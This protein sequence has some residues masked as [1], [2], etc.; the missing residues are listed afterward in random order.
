VT[1]HRTVIAVSLLCRNPESAPAKHAAV[2][3]IAGIVEG[4]GAGSAQVGV[5]MA[6]FV[7]PEGREGD[8]ATIK[9]SALR[10]YDIYGTHGGESSLKRADQ[11]LTRLAESGTTAA[12][13]RSFVT[14][15]LDTLMLDYEEMTLRI[16]FGEGRPLS[17]FLYL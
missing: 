9:E 16:P 2:E 1:K 6:V 13:G 10:F 17:P 11:I 3:V 15:M 8:L 12:V 7:L 14:G 5:R 4:S